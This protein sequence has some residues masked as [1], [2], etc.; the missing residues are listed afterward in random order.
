[1]IEREITLTNDSG[2]HARPAARFAKLASNF[3]SD[4]T[5]IY[6]EKKYNAKSV[7]RVMTLGIPYG[8]SFLLQVDGQDE[9]EALTELEE[10]ILHGLE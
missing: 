10:L 2:L 6:K 9:K 4:I 8:E 7:M 1:M 5:I 3:S